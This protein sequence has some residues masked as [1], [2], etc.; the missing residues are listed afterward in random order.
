MHHIKKSIE[1]KNK[2]SALQKNRKRV[3]C[4]YCGKELDIANA[5]RWHFDNCKHKNI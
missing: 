4:P 1:T 2:L 3:V 5:Y